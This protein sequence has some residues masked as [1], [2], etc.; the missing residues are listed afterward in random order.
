MN[1]ILLLIFIS[2]STYAADSIIKEKQ[3]EHIKLS[4]YT[5]LISCHNIDYLI[6]YKDVRRDD[7]ENI[8]KITLITS[9][10]QRIIVENK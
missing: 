3:C 1:K 10:D 6:E 8:K 4:K 2:L 5:T 9:K 7:E